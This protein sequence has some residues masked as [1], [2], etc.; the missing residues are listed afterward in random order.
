[1]K[2]WKKLK[3]FIGSRL[4]S[5]Y[6]VILFILAGLFAAF[7]LSK[8]F[9]QCKFF[10][11]VFFSLFSLLFLASIIMILQTYMKKTIVKVVS[12]CVIFILGVCCYYKENIIV[13]A[14]ASLAEFFPSRGSYTQDEYQGNTAMIVFYIASYFFAI[15]MLVSLFGRKLTNGWQRLFAILSNRSKCRVFWTKVPGEKEIL[16]ADNL[17]K[18]SAVRCIFSVEEFDLND[19][20]VFMEDLNFHGH[21]LYLRKP[22]QIHSGT[23]K[24]PVHFFITADCNWNIRMAQKVWDKIRAKGKIL[25]DIKFFVRISGGTKAVWSGTWA[26][27]L[28]AESGGKLEKFYH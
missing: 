7:W 20:A 14:C 9:F 16:L 2:M 22:E 28:Q 8:W 17:R 4:F 15:S 23:L 6:T 25:Q 24:P 18:G 10:T 26:E 19:E 1:M 5:E 21:L 13:S 27:K 3:Y 12:F 11:A